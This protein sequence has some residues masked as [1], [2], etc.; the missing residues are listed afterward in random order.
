MP[1]SQLPSGSEV[2]HVFD[3]QIARYPGNAEM[4]RTQENR[5]VNVLFAVASDLECSKWIMRI[6]G[7]AEYGLGSSDVFCRGRF[8]NAPRIAYQRL[9]QGL[10]L[11]LLKRAGKEQQVSRRKRKQMSELPDENTRP[12]HPQNQR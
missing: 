1:T 6:I 5:I 2:A 7:V 10:G 12:H 9:G 11:N 4:P 8:G 3:F